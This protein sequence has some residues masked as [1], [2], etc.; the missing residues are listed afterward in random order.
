MLDDNDLVEY[1]ILS[2]LAQS[3]GGFGDFLGSL[4]YAGLSLIFLGTALAI[5]L[6]PIFKILNSFFA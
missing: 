2:T 6:V 4:Y 3:L 1:H 5:F